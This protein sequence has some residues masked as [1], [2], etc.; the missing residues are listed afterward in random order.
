MKLFLIMEECRLIWQ[1]YL[2][3]VKEVEE[4]M[5]SLSLDKTKKTPGIFFLFFKRTFG[6]NQ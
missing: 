1:F 5:E 2:F 6:T 3:E 4:Q